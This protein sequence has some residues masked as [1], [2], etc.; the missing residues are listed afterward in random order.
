M[1]S[2]HGRYVGG[3]A[4]AALGMV[5][6]GTMSLQATR[7]A[8]RRYRLASGERDS[9]YKDRFF[10]IQDWK[11]SEIVFSQ[12]ILEVIWHSKMAVKSYHPLGPFSDPPRVKWV[13]CW[14]HWLKQ[15]PPNCRP[16]S[17]PPGHPVPSLRPSRQLLTVLLISGFYSSSEVLCVLLSDIFF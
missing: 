11:N 16:F 13:P 8:Y 10:D 14:T 17:T 4:R 1:R 2:S 7:G 15:M 5:G 12:Q 6:R 9:R 3:R